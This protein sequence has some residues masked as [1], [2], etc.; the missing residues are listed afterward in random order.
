MAVVP[1]NQDL[2]TAD[3]LKLARQVDPSGNRTL[4]VVTKVDIMDRGTDARAILLN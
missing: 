1:G 2:S 3:G 4:G